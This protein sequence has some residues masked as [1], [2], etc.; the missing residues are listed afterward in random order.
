MSPRLLVALTTTALLALT[1]CSRQ[2]QAECEKVCL[3]HA[4]LWFEDD[5]ARKLAETPEAEREALAGTKEAAWYE[6]ENDPYAPGREHCVRSCTK[7]ASKEQLDCILQTS[8]LS[9]AKACW[10]E[11]D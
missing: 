2:P 9:A 1:G 10:E 7:R 8:D 11:E 6:I 4:R 3:H 5:W